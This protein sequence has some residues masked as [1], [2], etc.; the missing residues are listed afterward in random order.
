MCKQINSLIQINQ[1]CGFTWT[2]VVKSVSRRSF[3]HLSY[4]SINILR[5][6][7]CSQLFLIKYKKSIFK[8]FQRNLA[9]ILPLQ[10]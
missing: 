9:F 5:L 10:L 7:S 4:R 6:D 8:A 2:N 3:F 1:K